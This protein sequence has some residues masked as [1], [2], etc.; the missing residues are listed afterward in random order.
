MWP[1]TE[2][3]FFLLIFSRMMRIILAADP[4]HAILKFP[5]IP[6]R[7][8][9]FSNT[10]FSFPGSFSPASSERVIDLRKDC[11]SSKKAM[12]WTKRLIVYYFNAPFLNVLDFLMSK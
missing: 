6:L 3:V 8:K 9:F 5:C 2:V 7:G 10:H 12:H 1:R 11:G 4:H